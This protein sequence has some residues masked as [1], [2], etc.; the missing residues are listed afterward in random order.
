MR[1]ALTV[2]VVTVGMEGEKRLREADLKRI[3][4]CSVAV[5]PR[6]TQLSKD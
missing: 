5:E 4:T 1:R 6:M 3:E 2:A